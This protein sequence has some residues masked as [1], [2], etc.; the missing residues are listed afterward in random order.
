MSK[1]AFFVLGTLL[2]YVFLCACQRRQCTSESFTVPP[3][4]TEQQQL[5]ERLTDG[6]V[7]KATYEV[8]GYYESGTQTNLEVLVYGEHVCGILQLDLSQSDTSLRELI[9]AKGKSYRGA[10]L[11]KPFIRAQATPEGVRYFLNKVAR[12]QD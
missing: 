6:T 10:I 11:E 7:P 9:A 2:S 5:W 8:L 12:I 4:V 1:H 3:T